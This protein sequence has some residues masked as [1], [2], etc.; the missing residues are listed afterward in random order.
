[1]TQSGR[2]SL[3]LA[4][5]GAAEALHVAWSLPARGAAVGRELGEALAG[6]GIS[7]SPVAEP[8]PEPEGEPTLGPDL[9]P[10]NSVV[11]SEPMAGDAAG[12]RGKRARRATAGRGVFVPAAVVLKLANSGAAPRGRPVPRTASHPSGVEVVGASALGVG[13]VDGDVITEVMGRPVHTEGEVVGL[14]LSARAH[15]QSLVGAVFWRHGEAWQLSVEMPY[16]S[17]S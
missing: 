3:V 7:V 5:F 11:D 9:D 16:P 15:R 1:M 17:A 12:H 10:S 2:A 4:I 13:M 6:T 14:V 8:D